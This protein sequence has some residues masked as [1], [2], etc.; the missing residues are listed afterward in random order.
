MRKFVT[1][2]CDCGNTFEARFKSNPK[3]CGCKSGFQVTHGQSQKGRT[4]AYR[5]WEAIKARCFNERTCGYESYGGRGI[6][7]CKEWA[8][9]FEAFFADM[10]ERPAGTTIDRIDPNGNYEK[11]NCRWATN[12][13]Q[14][15]N[16]REHTWLCVEGQSITMAEAVERYA[17]V[18][19]SGLSKRLHKHG[20][21]DHDAVFLP[22]KRANHKLTIY[23][24]VMPLKEWCKISGVK[25][26]TARNRLAIGWTHKE[27]VFGRAK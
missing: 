24:K 7:M 20:M 2:V 14:Q 16:R 8:E 4:P 12:K 19:K 17:T 27:A 26:G 15:R 13:Q 21:N 9:S 18:K 6:T 23:G 10:G 5:S 11:S 25:Y 22:P 1:C 3:S